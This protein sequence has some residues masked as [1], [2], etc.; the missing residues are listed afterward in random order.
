MLPDNFIYDLPL[1]F[2]KSS[3]GDPRYEERHQSRNARSDMFVHLKL[4]GSLNWR[5]C[6]HGHL[7]IEDPTVRDEIRCPIDHSRVEYFIIPPSTVKDY[8]EPSISTI[9]KEAGRRLS[10]VGHILVYGF[11]FRPADYAA[12]NLL[13]VSLAKSKEVKKITIVDEKPELVEKSIRSVVH[14]KVNFS[15]FKSWKEL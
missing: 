3:P 9:W 8:S 1:C 10:E 13:L 12:R 2:S 5:K 11:S 7:F 6:P 15:R 4:H 14:Q